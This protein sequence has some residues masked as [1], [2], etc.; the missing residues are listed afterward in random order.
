MP[1][2]FSH[3]NIISANWHR[4]ADFYVKVFECKPVPPARNL[5]GGWLEKGTGVKAAHLEGI[6]LRLPGCGES[7]P[8]LEIY[9]YSEMLGSSGTPAANRL[10]FG[11]IAFRVDDVRKTLD[12]VVSHG[13]SRLGEVVTHE[14]AGVGRLTF[15]YASDPDGNIIEIQKWD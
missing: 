15:T 13:G 3:T 6:H 8:T 12:T 1:A 4:L 7:G 5:S 10:G 14:V 2:V 11:H 9:S